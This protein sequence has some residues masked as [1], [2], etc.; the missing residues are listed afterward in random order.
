MGDR[1]WVTIKF[2]KTDLEKFNEALIGKTWGDNMPWWDDFYDEGSTVFTQVHEA[3]YG[4]YDVFQDLASEGLTFLANNGAG[5]E[6]G[7][8]TQV[9][10]K[11]NLIDLNAN[12]ENYPVI[13][14]SPDGITDSEKLETIKE[15]WKLEKLIN[16]YFEEVT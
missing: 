11:G 1:T 8:G 4:W 10:F 3:N 13:E 15:Y 5:D 6:Y 14:V 2:K 9:C 12:N 16:K 7:H